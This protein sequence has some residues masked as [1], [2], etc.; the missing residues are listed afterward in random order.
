MRRE[1]RIRELESNLVVP[2]ARRAVRDR[3]GVLL[4]RDVDLR[5]GDQ[6]TRDRGAEQVAALVN[7]I[8]AEHR[9]DEVPDELFAEIDDVHAR[10]AGAQGLVPDGN[11]LLAL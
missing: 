10:R 7:R 9:I 11:Q 1:R 5:T 2:L 8:R 4:E 3:G 6:R